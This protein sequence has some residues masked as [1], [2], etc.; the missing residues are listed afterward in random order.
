MAHGAAFRHTYTA[1]STNTTAKRRTTTHWHCTYA[2]F[3]AFED[4][5]H[6]LQ[7]AEEDVAS[8]RRKLEDMIIEA[9]TQA[10]EPDASARKGVMP[11]A[12]TN[13]LAEQGRTFGPL[14]CAAMNAFSGKQ[15]G[16]FEAFRCASNRSRSSSLK[17]LQGLSGSMAF[18]DFENDER[19]AVVWQRPWPTCCLAVPVLHPEG[20]P[21]LAWLTPAFVFV[22]AEAF[23]VPFMLSFSVDTDD[24]ATGL[25][26]KLVDL[27]F[28]MDI[29]V[30]FVTGFRDARGNM[31]LKPVAIAK[32]YLAGWFA[33]DAV[34][35]IPWSW[36]GDTS[37]AQVTRG[38]KVVRLAR[39]ARLLRLAKLRAITEA[40]ET[41][42]EGRYVAEL[43]MG[44]GKVLLL[45]FAVAHWCACFW[46]AVGTSQE[47]GWVSELEKGYE[48]DNLIYARYTWSLYFTL[49]TLTTV[50][51][52]DITPRT[53]DECRWVLLLLLTS[54]VIFSGL[55][56]MLSD[57][58]AS[59][60]KE[61]RIIGLKKRQLAR[62]M[63]WR[64]IPRN[65]LVKVRRFF[66]FKWGAQKDYDLYEEELKQ[67]LTPTLRSELCF[68]I[69]KD[70]LHAAP[71]LAWMR[72]Y[73]A[74]L[75]NLAVSVRSGFH[76]SGDFLL[77]AGEEIKDV[78]ILL[79]GT[80]VLYRRDADAEQCDQEDEICPEEEG[81]VQRAVTQHS[82]ISRAQRFKQLILHRHVKRQTTGTA[83]VSSRTEELETQF[84]GT[85]YSENIARA[86]KELKRQDSVQ[87]RAAAFIQSAWRDHIKSRR[88]EGL[89]FG[90]LRVG[91]YPLD[92]PAY[93]GESC[94]WAPYSTWKRRAAIHRYT[95]R[96]KT[97][98]EVVSVPRSAIGQCIEK[99]SPWL[100]NRFEVF[101][102]A[103]LADAVIQE[104]EEGVVQEVSERD[105]RRVKSAKSNFMGF[106]AVRSAQVVPSAPEDA[107]TQMK[108]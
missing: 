8:V 107:C 12:S 97:Q 99:F 34:A 59:V 33:L 67:K 98:V 6:A 63:T 83:L 72:G 90:L 29:V 81:L 5:I 50:G 48:G 77:R 26:F 40:A 20:A 23:L 76:D 4:S 65:L 19:G 13:W 28:L 70:V 14:D 55:L 78:V 41:Y 42:M 39:L 80:A 75:R 1:S 36:I 9:G 108:L 103:V 71:F 27:Y 87:R 100:Q 37:V 38:L 95:V 43:L 61:H 17:M 31:E 92:A 74:C 64:A 22:L 52:G 85:C 66:L 47:G 56:G 25:A 32:H 58:V 18:R 53:T 82:K 44:F 69:F 86:V 16:H 51:Y 79:A 68:H 106:D 57:L 96:C 21:R 7:K 3:A 91:G 60:N 105:I 73:K 11:S 15:R 93:F 45:L 84:F 49:T 102:S 104:E 2:D 62:Y 101:Q 35:A 24:G 89:K 54:A 46:H 30:T 88:N 10:V 94:L